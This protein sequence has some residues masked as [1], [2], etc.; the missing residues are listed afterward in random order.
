MVVGETGRAFAVL[1]EERQVLA[2]ASNHPIV[3]AN[4]R[5]SASVVLGH[6]SIRAKMVL[7]K[8]SL[9]LACV[10]KGSL[11]AAH[12]DLDLSHTGLKHC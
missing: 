7:N 6:I 4:Q 8:K 2:A 9:P 11:N 10:F 5:W 1:V 12:V 3:I